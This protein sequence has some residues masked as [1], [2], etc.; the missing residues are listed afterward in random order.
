MHPFI[1]LRRVWWPWC[2][3]LLLSGCIDPYL[4]EG[5]GAAPNYLVVDGYLNS[6]GRSLIQLSRT[7]RLDQNTAP[8]RETGATL[9]IE[10]Q[11]GPR[12]PLSETAPGTYTSIPLN[13]STESNYR[14]YILTAEG[15]EYASA[16][17]PAKVTPPIDSVTWR[18]NDNG[19]TIY[20]N[21]HDDT[22]STQ[23]Y[24]WDFDE[25]WEI[26]PTIIPQYE[27][28]G[29]DV[30]L[31]S[32]P[33][34]DVCWGNSPS[35]AV[36]LAKTTN[37]SQDRIA[38]FPLQSYPRTSERIGHKYSILVRQFAQTREEYQYW[39]LLQKNTENI[40]T[41]FDPLPSQLTGNIRSLT[42]EGE[43][44]LG[45]VGAYSRQ[46]KRIFISRA[47]LP[48][49]W[50][51]ITGYES[52]SPPDT[53]LMKDVLAVFRG[54]FTVPVE[55]VFYSSGAIQGYTSTTL[56]CADCRKRGTAVRPNFWQ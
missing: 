37:L 26:V 1:S 48:G 40:G 13:F 20:V 30:R 12:F 11:D 2:V 19:L 36:R 34:P 33:Y 5:V 14:L 32:V 52:C 23:Y 39:E 28:R 53:V 24:R 15:K 25:T 41:L 29:G 44:V 50:P 10:Q 7:Y 46:E 43:V 31:I 9:F 4:P 8:P 55:Q 3:L 54:G 17:M 38:D 27:F 47:E 21:S 42:D 45:Y 18:V 16:F 35:T 51:Y 6:R 22:N 49:T 56:D